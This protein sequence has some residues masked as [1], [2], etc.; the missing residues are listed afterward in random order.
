MPS[1]DPPFTRPLEWKKIYREDMSMEGD[2]SASEHGDLRVQIA[3]SDYNV[4]DSDWAKQ[5]QFAYIRNTLITTKTGKLLLK[6]DVRIEKGDCWAKMGD[7]TGFSHF[8]V[9]LSTYLL[10]RLWKKVGERYRVVQEER[11]GLADIWEAVLRGEGDKNYR[12]IYSGDEFINFSVTTRNSYD[13]GDQ[14][15]VDFGVYGAYD[16]DVD[17]YEVKASHVVG[18][19]RVDKINAEVV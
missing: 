1:W 5:H 6:A 12:D 19:V 8:R 3:C 16:V 17:D 7:E 15:F 11:F 13:E 4:D 18:R 9:S 2:P 14:F 10:F